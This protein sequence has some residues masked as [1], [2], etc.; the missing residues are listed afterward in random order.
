MTT[1]RAL[2]SAALAALLLAPA[3]AL[4]P[5]AGFAQQAGQTPQQQTAPAQR[6]ESYDPMQVGQPVQ[7]E[8][9]ML[10]GNVLCVDLASARSQQ[11]AV[12]QAPGSRMSQGGGQGG[13]QLGQGGGQMNA[14][15]PSAGGQADGRV[16]GENAQ[17]L[18]GRL[19]EQVLAQ[20]VHDRLLCADLDT[21]QAG[22][23]GPPGGQ[24]GQGNQ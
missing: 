7:V 13:G 3:A 5:H 8:A 2:R 22:R 20:L 11:M 6:L 18:T 17:R 9:R 14:Q 4:G 23:G 19:G 24:S 1:F 15:P 21:W 10:P 16:L 12:T